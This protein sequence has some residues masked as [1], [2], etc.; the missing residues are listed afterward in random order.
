MTADEIAERLDEAR[1]K[2]ASPTPRTASS[3]RA[4]GAAALAALSALG[5]ATAVILGPGHEAK[6]AAPPTIFGDR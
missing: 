1:E 3:A 4:L 2:L 5:L 6:D